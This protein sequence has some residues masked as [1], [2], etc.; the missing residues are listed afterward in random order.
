MCSRRRD[1]LLDELVV[2]FVDE[3]ALLELKVELEALACAVCMYVC[4]YVCRSG[5]A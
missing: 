5:I 4:I 1:E 2:V 3:V